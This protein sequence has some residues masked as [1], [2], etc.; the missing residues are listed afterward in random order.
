MSFAT[1]HNPLQGIRVSGSTGNYSDVPCPSE[2]KYLLEDVSESDAGR[3]E[4]ANMW[5]KRIG[6]VVGLE[7]SWKGITTTQLNTILTL[8]NPEYIDVKYLDPYKGAAN[9]DYIRSDI[10]YVGNRSAPMY[11][12]LMNLWEN[13]SFKI[14]RRSG[15]SL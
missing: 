11:S 1:D 8:F 9:A 2:Y 12:S 13:V 3:T 7:L 6:Q 4:D 5:K 14:V 15:G 10:F